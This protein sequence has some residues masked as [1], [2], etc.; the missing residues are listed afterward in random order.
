M[1]RLVR[2]PVP[3]IPPAPVPPVPLGA[4]GAVQGAPPAAPA[5][6]PTA[7]TY[8]DR[9]AKY[10]PAEV[11]GFYLFVNNVI[12]QAVKSTP[13][14][15]SPT[16]ATLPIAWIAWGT[17]LA[18]LAATPLYI[19]YVKEKGDAW[20]TNAFVSTLAFPIWAYA[21][22]GVVFGATRDGNFASILLAAFTLASGLITPPTAK[23]AA[24]A[25]AG[26][27]AGAG[28]GAGAGG[29]GAG[30]AGAGGAGAGGAGAGGAGGG[31]DS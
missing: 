20:V 21:M 25:G 14:G 29:A 23:P 12:D 27:A 11:V 3:E 24:G 16:M 10:V 2:S 19:A 4:A 9:V 13:T 8:L 6:K 1:S 17:F 22:N 5:A 7:D 30:G 31:A 28:G 15:T 18:G 26:G